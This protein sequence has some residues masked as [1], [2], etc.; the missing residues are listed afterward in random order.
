MSDSSVEKPHIVRVVA[1]EARRQFYGMPRSHPP[2]PRILEDEI[3][4]E[5]EDGRFIPFAD[6]GYHADIGFFRLS[7]TT[8]VTNEAAPFA[9]AGQLVDCG[10]IVVTPGISKRISN[11]EIRGLLARHAAGDFGDYGE[12][13][14]LDVTDEM[15]RERPAHLMTPGLLSKV[16]ALSGL[17]PVASAYAIGEHQVWLITEA[18]QKPTT[19][20]LYAG[21]AADAS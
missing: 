14:D 10:Q 19:I 4:V 7:E 20:L 12:F 11:E 9:A 13:Y 17:N 16:N 1:G 15:L 8:G 18:G 3:G 6:L 2:R 5:F 21:P